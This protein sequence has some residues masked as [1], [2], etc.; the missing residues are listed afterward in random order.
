MSGDSAAYDYLRTHNFTRIPSPYTEIVQGLIS[1]EEIREVRA[2][3]VL[4]ELQRQMDNAENAELAVMLER[5]V[6]CLPQ[7]ISVTR[8]DLLSWER[9]CQ[10]GLLPILAENSDL[11]RKYNYWQLIDGIIAE[12]NMAVLR[13]VVANR[14]LKPSQ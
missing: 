3:D 11:R 7:R 1:F 5:L 8:Y 6:D 12:N 13:Y 4:D 14:W 9:A 2:D 10:D